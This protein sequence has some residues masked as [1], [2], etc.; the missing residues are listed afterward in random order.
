M[1]KFTEMVTAS[2]Q[3][4]K[5]VTTGVS[6]SAL[7][8]MSLYKKAIINVIANKPLDATGTAGNLSVT[9]YESTASTWNGAVAKTNS[10]LTDKTSSCYS[11]STGYV[12]YEINDYD[13]T[14]NSGYR[15]VGFKTAMWTATDMMAIVERYRAD[16]EPLE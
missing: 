13:L 5:T 10:V 15:Y 9:I 6:S 1:N 2:V 7:L 16:N 12:R 8:D 3:V 14:I 11:A 4:A